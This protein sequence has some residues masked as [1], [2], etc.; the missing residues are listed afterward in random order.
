MATA[1]AMAHIINGR[2]DLL[3]RLRKY[4][5]RTDFPAMVTAIAAT[6]CRANSSTLPLSSLRMPGIRIAL[7]IILKVDR[8]LQRNVVT[9]AG[10]HWCLK[11][12]VSEL[13]TQR[14]MRISESLSHP[15]FLVAGAVKRCRISVSHSWTQADPFGVASILRRDPSAHRA[16]ATI[17]SQ[18]LGVKG[19]RNP[20]VGF[21]EMTA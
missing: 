10:R 4:P 19:N 6:L 1:T 11:K 9:V 2:A 3:K 16:A 5:S 13:E 12:A 17:V 8:I 7:V 14:L 15:W 20:I 21:A 18:L